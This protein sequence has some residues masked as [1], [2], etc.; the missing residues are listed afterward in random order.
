M[1]QAMRHLEEGMDVPAGNAT[2]D[3]P[4]QVPLATPTPEQVR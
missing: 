1:S 4:T 3:L 2:Q